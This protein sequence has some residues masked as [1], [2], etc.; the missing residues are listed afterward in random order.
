[1]DDAAV[2]DL[3]DFFYFVQVVD[4]GGFTAAGRMLS[5]SSTELAATAEQMSKLSRVLLE[6]MDRFVLDEGSSE[7]RRNFGRRHTGNSSDSGR[8]ANE[9]AELVRA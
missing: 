9:Y 2:L 5:S 6:S 8:G 7:G 1:M 4:R 3:N